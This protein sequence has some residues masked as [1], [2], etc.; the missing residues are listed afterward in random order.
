MNGNQRRLSLIELLHPD[1]VVDSV[2]VI[3]SACRDELVLCPQDQGRPSSVAGLVVLAP[4]HE[5][6][7]DPDWLRAAVEEASQALRRNGV[8]Y[9]LAERYW[10]GHALRLLRECG[11]L[12][13]KVYLHHPRWPETHLLI[14]ASFDAVA[15]AYSRLIHTNP[16]RRNLALTALS[17][18]GALRI[19]AQLFAQTGLLARH[20]EAQP[21][22]KWLPEGSGEG[23]QAIVHA[24]WRGPSGAVLLHAL[25][26]DSEAAAIAKVWLSEAGTE[27]FSREMSGLRLAESTNGA[28]GATVPHLLRHGDL[29]GRP[30]LVES[31]VT[32][33]KAAEALGREPALLPAVLSQLAD[34]LAHWNSVTARI[35]LVTEEEI[36]RLALGPARMLA[37]EL[38]F[39]GQYEAKLRELGGR[40]LA[41]PARSVA[42]HGDLTMVNV[43]IGENDGRLGV[44]DWEE[45]SS[46]GLP[47]A[48]WFYAAVDAVAATGGYRDRVAAWDACFGPHGAQRPLIAS[49]QAP[50]AEVTGLNPDLVSFSFHACWLK[51]ALGER[52]ETAKAAPDEFLSIARRA[53]AALIH[54]PEGTGGP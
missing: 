37:G 13:E 3:G 33:E 12:V 53:A 11:L 23:R 22:L 10:R 29:R 8:L 50:L 20:P 32:G 54:G 28:A 19:A 1:G 48:D 38:G 49:L 45:A 26:R 42:S 24:S 46:D 34:W 2:R 30:Y 17:A 9:V 47:L 18:P 4:T 15:Y 43:L 52:R 39:D 6:G 36:E 25:T 41:R 21:A 31:V 7:A 51:H 16:T 27:A 5:E 44:I 40:M 35:H 14:P